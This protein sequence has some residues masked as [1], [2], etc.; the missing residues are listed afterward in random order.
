MNSE[1]CCALSISILPFKSAM[2]YFG[3]YL[4]QMA[5]RVSKSLWSDQDEDGTEQ[6]LGAG[7][8]TVEAEVRIIGYRI[9]DSG[10]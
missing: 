5:N 6:D 7:G 2:C 8:D 9:M 4:L 1:T 3:V 10:G